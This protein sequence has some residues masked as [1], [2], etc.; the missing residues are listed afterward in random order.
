MCFSFW[1]FLSFL[2]CIITLSLLQNNTK[3]DAIRGTTLSLVRNFR[4]Q[5]TSFVVLEVATYS[6]F[7]VKSAMQGRF[8]ISL[9]NTFNVT[10]SIHLMD[11]E[12]RDS[13][14]IKSTI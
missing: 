4:S 9:F 5:I 10:T 12:T 13:I 6:T 11:D 8:S 3:G 2:D 1:W 14:V 7:I